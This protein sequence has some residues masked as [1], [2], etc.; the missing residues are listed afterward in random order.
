MAQIPTGEKR[1]SQINA[2]VTSVNSNSLTTLST[3]ANSYTGGNAVYTNNV[4]VEPHG[5]NEFS[6]YTHGPQNHT[7]GWLRNGPVG[8]VGQYYTSN[9]TGTAVPF[10]SNN[11]SGWTMGGGFNTFY[12]YWSG[13]RNDSWTYLTIGS[14]V[15][16]RTSASSTT[17]T[18]HV[19]SG[20]TTTNKNAIIGTTTGVFTYG[21]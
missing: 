14:Y 6:G 20:L 4:G 2:E 19:Y 10:G 5:M 7:I 18:S 16:Y 3:S 1:I 15:A 11:W 9:E 8:K 21:P 17:S 13:G 12:I